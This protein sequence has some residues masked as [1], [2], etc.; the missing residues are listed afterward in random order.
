MV[1]RLSN[2]NLTSTGVRG[3]RVVGSPWASSVLC[4]AHD[5]RAAIPTIHEETNE[6]PQRERGGDKGRAHRHTVARYLELG[7]GPVTAAALAPERGRRRPDPLKP[8]WP[9]A[10]PFLAETPGLEAKALFTHLLARVSE[11]ARMAASRA[12]RTFQRRVE[13]WRRRHGP[14]VGPDLQGPHD[15]HG[16]HRPIGAPRHHPGYLPARTNASAKPQNR[17]PDGGPSGRPPPAPFPFYLDT[18]NKHPNPVCR[19]RSR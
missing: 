16:R 13:K 12:L 10:E 14:P 8:I 19:H 1:G 5:H 4:A 7:H 15:H 9:L 6:G 11:E 17:P 18:S 2:V 3:L